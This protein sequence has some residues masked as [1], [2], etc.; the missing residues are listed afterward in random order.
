MVAHGPF[1]ARAAVHRQPAAPGRAV[2]PGFLRRCAI[3]TDAYELFRR[4]SE[5][6]AGRHAHQA[7]IAL[8]RARDAAPEHASVREALARAYYGAG[9]P[10]DAGAEFAKALEIDPTNDYAHFGLALCLA[11]GGERALAVGHL[12]LALAMRPGVDAYRQALQRLAG[13]PG[14]GPGAPDGG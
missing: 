11:R 3:E 9:R 6:L 14:P 1:V 10:A 7:V 8:E 5:L 13:D 2:G 12:R 4:G